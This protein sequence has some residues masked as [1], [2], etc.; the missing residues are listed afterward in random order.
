[1]YGKFVFQATKSIL[2]QA[3]SVLLQQTKLGIFFKAYFVF[4]GE[5][6]DTCPLNEG[7]MDLLI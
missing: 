7:G 2:W 3:S 1:M 6:I 5:K 4:V